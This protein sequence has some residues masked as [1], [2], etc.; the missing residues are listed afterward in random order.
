MS[1]KSTTT[2][3]CGTCRH[4]W[5]LDRQ[6][7]KEMAGTCESLSH[8]PFRLASDA[9]IFASCWGECAVKELNH[10]D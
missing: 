7:W 1:N 6:R 9:P 3:Q 4:F 8:T 2:K 5:A 10:A